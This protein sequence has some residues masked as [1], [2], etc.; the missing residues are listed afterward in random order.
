MN[1]T[2]T[3]IGQMVAFI[4]LIWL[5]NKI[6]W[7][8]LS[9][10]MADRQARIADGLAAGERGKQE[11][12]QAAKRVAQELDAA[13]A[14]AS[15][16]IGQAEKRAGEIVEEARANARTEGSRILA[17]AKAEIDQQV[18]HAKESLREQVTQLAVAGAE[19]ILHREIDAKAHADLLTQL[20][21]EIH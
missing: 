1:I 16:I 3:L 6:L 20:K 7:G 5:V 13:K 21:Q 4:L 18:N 19:K 14:K 11:L 12:E 10:M 9:K 8:P 2:V 15:E 17:G